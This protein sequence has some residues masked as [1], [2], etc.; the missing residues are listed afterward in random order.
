MVKEWGTVGPSGNNEGFSMKEG[1]ENIWGSHSFWMVLCCAIPLMGI[2]VLSLLGILGS[3][4][5]YALI[6]LCPLL[7]LF[8]M[9]RMASKDMRKGSS[10]NHMMGP[11]T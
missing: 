7:H 10:K 6:L 3:W 4:G 1:K 5:F 2:I 11:G 8:F 9:R